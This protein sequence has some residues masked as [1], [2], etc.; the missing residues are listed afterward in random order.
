MKNSLKRFL[1]ISIFS[2][3]L[4]APLA[5]KADITFPARLEIT[6]I[7]PGIYEVFFVLPV[8]NGK[9]LKAHPVFP[10]AFT[11]LDEPKIEGDNNTK[12]MTWRVS[13]D[14][15][16]ISGLKIGIDGLL[17]SPT[18]VF[19]KLSL[20]NGRSYDTKLSPASAFYM[21]PAPP[22]FLSL[23]K[24]AFINGIQLV[25]SFN[26]FYLFL[27]ILLPFLTNRFLQKLLIIFGV[28]SLLGLW[29]SIQ[30]YLVFSKYHFAFILLLTSLF[31]AFNLLKLP[32]TAFKD[33]TTATFSLLLGLAYGGVLSPHTDLTGFTSSDVITY[34]TAMILG[35]LLGLELI[36]LMLKELIILLTYLF[37]NKTEPIFAYSVGILSFAFLIYECSLYITAPS[38][39]PNLPLVLIVFA[40]VASFSLK[41]IN[42]GNTLVKTMLFLA[43]LALGIS[44]GFQGIQIP[45]AFTIL[46]GCIWFL[47]LSY[48]YTSLQTKLFQLFILTLAGI[49][50]GMLLAEYTRDS[51]SFALGQTTGYLIILL[52]F[53]TNILR[54][55]TETT[56]EKSRP[57]KFIITLIIFLSLIYIW[58]QGFSS[59]LFQTIQTDFTMGLLHL[60]VLSI[61]LLI[62]VWVAWPR[63]KKIHKAMNME[64]KKP[65]L[66]YLFL[67]L[68][69]LLI[70]I[71]IKASNPWHVFEEPTQAEVQQITQR[72][73][74]NAYTAFNLK[75][76]TQLFT[77]LSNNLEGALVD[78]VYLDSRR[79]LTMGLKDGAEVTVETVVVSNIGE[80]LPTDDLATVFKYPTEWTVTARVRHL[81][82]VHYRQ[83]KYLGEITLKI[84]DNVW[85]IS[86][87]TLTSEDRTIISANNK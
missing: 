70:P 10:D 44:F 82:H 54:V 60:P 19:F 55:K 18:D 67:G 2:L 38:M 39:L 17:G 6:E 11:I 51:L 83:N 8:I 49:L 69:L 53:L 14:P 36:V 59:E 46:L 84:S 74:T 57:Y 37:K 12:R 68:A 27:L 81:Q 42:H 66:S 76:E 3:C 13:C 34:L 1:A 85:K 65:M 62:L 73:L 32:K 41:R 20:L 7:S 56:S 24:E 63:Y 79:R 45:F 5:L 40:L 31:S 72:I 23:T 47:F 48:S 75:D 78:N 25:L 29:L 22:T 16:K 50:T 28:F 87:M 26:V 71:T 86:N 80:R 21:I 33:A 58:F 9:V 35:V 4:L 64:R 30:E 77:I 43:P 15:D 61:I 52:L